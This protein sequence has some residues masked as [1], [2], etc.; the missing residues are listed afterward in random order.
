MAAPMRSTHLS[1]LLPVLVHCHALEVGLMAGDPGR[2]LRH[3]SITEIFPVPSSKLFIRP[4]RPDCIFACSF[5]LQAL[6][7]QLMKK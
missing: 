7:W 6:S 3:G 1:T 5:A 4:Q 2:A